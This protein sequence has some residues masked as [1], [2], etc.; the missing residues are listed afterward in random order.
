MALQTDKFD[1]PERLITADKES[2]REE[3]LER[4]LRPKKLAVYVGQQKIREQL[5]IFIQAATQRKEALD[6]VLLFG[7]PPFLPSFRF[8]VHWAICQS[9]DSLAA[10]SETRTRRN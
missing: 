6:H 4:A 9:L 8:E 5:E 7:P 10:S 2:S 1:T 3:A